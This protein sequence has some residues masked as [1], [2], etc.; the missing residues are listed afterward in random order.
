MPRFEVRADE[1]VPKLWYRVDKCAA[2]CEKL[3][4]P[5]SSRSGGIFTDSQPKTLF[6]PVLAKTAVMSELELFVKGLALLGRQR[7]IESLGGDEACFLFGD[8][9]F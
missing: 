7:G 4:Y 8:M 9:L 1:S 2:I 3:T 5:P 6:H